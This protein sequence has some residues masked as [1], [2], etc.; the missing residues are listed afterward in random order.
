[1]CPMCLTT[2][3]VVGAST[4]SGAGVLALVV[5]KVRAW[6]RRLRAAGG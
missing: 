4:A 1:M 2:V 6:R 3:A 5:V